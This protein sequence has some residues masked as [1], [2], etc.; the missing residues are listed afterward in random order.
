MS[1]LSI[2]IPAPEK[3]QPPPTPRLLQISIRHWLC[4]KTDPEQPIFAISQPVKDTSHTF[5]FS[6]FHSVSF[7][8][9]LFSFF[10]IED[11]LFI[12]RN[13]D[14]PVKGGREVL[15]SCSRSLVNYRH[16]LVRYKYGNK[17]AR[18]PPGTSTKYEYYTIHHPEAIYPCAQHSPRTKLPRSLIH[19]LYPPP[20][21]PKPKTPIT[22]FH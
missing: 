11:V 4:S 1:H 20:S 12:S 8:F 7:F 2:A 18:S 3:K 19:S 6:F 17:R 5:F 9:F 16:G 15:I 10:P 14:S 13:N 21:G 22:N